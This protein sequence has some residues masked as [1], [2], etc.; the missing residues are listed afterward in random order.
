M[1]HLTARKSDIGRDPGLG[2]AISFFSQFS[3]SSLWRTCFP[4]KSSKT[5]RVV[6]GCEDSSVLRLCRT[7][8]CP[9]RSFEQAANRGRHLT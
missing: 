4:D 1:W 6:T 3:L 9:L 7:V 8:Q 5:E 2:R